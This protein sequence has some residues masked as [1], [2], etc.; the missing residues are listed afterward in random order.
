[1]SEKRVI[2]VGVCTVRRPGMLGNC[3]NSLAKQEDVS[4]IDLHIVVADNDSAPTS[5]RVVEEFAQSSPFPVHYY[6]EPRRGIPMARNS[7]LEAALALNA[8]RLAF[9]DDDQIARPTFLAKHLEAALRDGADAVQP[10]IVPI[11]PDPAPFWSIG[12]NA[13]I[14]DAESDTALE[15]RLQRS[16]GTCGVMF[17]TRLIRADGM[18]LRFDENLALAGGEDAE[19]FHNA[20]RQGARIV[21]SRMPVVMEEVAITRLTYWRYAMRGLARGGQ[22]FGL[23]RRKNGYGRAV[24]KYFFVSLVRILRG[25]GQLVIA[26]VFAPFDLRRFK[27]TAL[28]GGRNIFLAAGTLGGIFSLQYQYY[29]QIDGY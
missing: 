25:T 16:A 10:H 8:E 7:V 2:C 29:R 26:P 23:Y 11:Y 22:L 20:Y 12:V 27:F 24:R 4:G 6:H 28:E 14:T 5:R 17:S 18:G 15:T 21:F 9:I 1:M 3:L 13:D 19:F